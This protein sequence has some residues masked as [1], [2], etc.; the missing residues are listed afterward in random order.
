MSAKFIIGILL[1]PVISM[2]AAALPNANEKALGCS[3]KIGCEGYLPTTTG[4]AAVISQEESLALRLQMIKSARKN[5]KIQALIFTGDEAGMRVAEVLKQKRAEGVQV[6]VIID[7]LSNPS[8]ATQWMYYDLL[9]HG[10]DIEGYEPALLQWMNEVNV[11]PMIVNKRFHE[12]I[13]AVDD[14]LAVVGGLNIANEYFRV[15]KGPKGI[16]RDQDV[17]VRGKIVHD[18]TAVFDRNYG[19]FKMLKGMRPDLFN[20]DSW[21]SALSG[22]NKFVGKVFGQ[23]PGKEKIQA[24]ILAAEDM[25][26]IPRYV[27]ASMRFIQS[28]PR[29]EESYIYREYI[30]QLNQAHS[31]VTIVNA[32]FVPGHDFTAAV[33]AAQARGVKI[34]ILT[35][36]PKTNDLPQLTYVGRQFYS[37]LYNGNLHMYEWQGDKYGEG[38]IHAKFA[39]FDR[40]NS[41]VGSYNLDPRSEKLNSESVLVVHSARIAETLLRTVE[42]SDLKK[43]EIIT[44]EKARSFKNKDLPTIF[45]A[46]LGMPL[47]DW[48]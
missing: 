26:I 33:R 2:A 25:K 32:Y 28:R 19:Y 39:V 7:G 9:N 43:S 6:Q 44:L 37:Q 8:Q 34:T 31:E 4:Q 48:L 47:K 10:I 20:P 16:W 1:F 11:N 24:K 41:I 40:K 22:I 5:I 29:F 23:F 14:K 27:D 42:T 15:G 3:P 35:N 36:S 30:N 38:T 46:A 17:I 18:I 45:N 21:R 12:K 13:F